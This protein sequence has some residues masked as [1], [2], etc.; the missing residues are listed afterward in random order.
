M[1]NRLRDLGAIG[2]RDASSS[3]LPPDATSLF[4]FYRL[5][6]RGVGWGGVR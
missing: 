3:D 1:N 6:K 2:T 4:S 5:L